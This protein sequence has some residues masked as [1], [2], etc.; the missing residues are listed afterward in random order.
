MF[1]PIYADQPDLWQADLIF[2]PYVNA[3]GETILQ[4]LLCVMNINTKYAFC[5]PID[6]VKNIKKMNERTWNDKSTHVLLNNKE[7]P[8]VLSSFKRIFVDMKGEA[9]VLN[10]FEK[11]EGKVKFNIKRLYVDKGGEFKGEFLAF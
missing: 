4:G 6:Y 2:E 8:L 10:G 5:K 11:L 7:V 3:K 1:F 9:E